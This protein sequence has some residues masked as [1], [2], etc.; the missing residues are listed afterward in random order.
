[1]PFGGWH[2]SIALLKRLTRPIPAVFVPAAR[3]PTAAVSSL[4]SQAAAGPLL[5]VA[6]KSSLD[7]HPRRSGR[8]PVRSLHRK[9]S[10]LDRIWRN[11]SDGEG[12][13]GRDRWGLSS[14]KL[15]KKSAG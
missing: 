7:P 5:L 3:V 8:K 9:S 13:T 10:N 11:A 2:S 14:A 6:S 1:M 12:R 15:H 4:A